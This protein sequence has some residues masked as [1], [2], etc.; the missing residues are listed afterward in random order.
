MQIQPI[1]IISQSLS[2]IGIVAADTGAAGNDLKLGRTAFRQMLDTLSVNGQFAPLTLVRT[3]PLTEETY[4]YTIGEGTDNDG[5]TADFAAPRPSRVLSAAIIL[6]GQSTRRRVIVAD[7]NEYHERI[8]KEYDP[9]TRSTTPS[10]MWLQRTHPHGTI[11]LSESPYV[12]LTLELY[13]VPAFD[14]DAEYNTMMEMDD[15]YSELFIYNLAVRLCPHFGREPTPAIVAIATQTYNDMLS[16]SHRAGLPD[17][18]YARE[19]S[20]FSIYAGPNV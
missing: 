5:E 8:I 4:V 13:Y 15:G 17:S 3:F 1:E 11:R 10:V 7:E 18:P 19:G 20:E 12:G 2:L 6:P 14:T 16:R 9:S